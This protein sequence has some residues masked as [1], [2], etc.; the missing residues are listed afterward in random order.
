M[1]A[2]QT[3]Q[4]FHFEPLMKAYQRA[5]ADEYY[6]T[7]DSALVERNGGKVKVVMGSYSNIKLTTPDDIPVA[8]SFLRRKTGMQS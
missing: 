8:E 2:I 1:W 4:V 3:P 5:V 6:S 7:D